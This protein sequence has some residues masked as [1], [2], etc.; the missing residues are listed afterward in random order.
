MSSRSERCLAKAEECQQI[1][2]AADA[3]GTTRLDGVLASQWR[4]LADETDETD[5]KPLLEN[6]THFLQ[7]ID[8]AGEQSES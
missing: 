7:E 5:K 6:H 3:S 1:S 8:N 4:Q 2:N